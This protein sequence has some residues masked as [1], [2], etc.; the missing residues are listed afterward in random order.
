MG[1]ALTHLAN[2]TWQEGDLDGAIK[3][4]AAALA[5]FQEVG[6]KLNV[7]A[8]KD[9][10]GSVHYLEG[11]LKISRDLLQEALA[12]FRDVGSKSSVA[13]ALENLAATTFSQGD[14]EA[15]REM[16]EE[17]IAIDR[18]QGVKSEVAWGLAG[19]GD[20]DLAEAKLDDAS[21]N[22]QEALSLRIEIGEKGTIAESQLSIATLALEQGQPV[23]AE[24]RVRDAREEFRKEKQIDDE[25]LADTCLARALLAQHNY[26]EARKEI[27]AGKALVSRSQ[28]RANQLQL[29]MAA[30]EL[31]SDQNQLEEAGRHLIAIL[32]AAK[33]I[34]LLEYQF[35]ARLELGKIEM[36]SGKSSVGASHLH[37]LQEVAT[38]KGFLLIASKAAK[39]RAE[40]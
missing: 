32:S 2:V 23:A 1:T 18:K 30:G 11:H 28:N 5:N 38:T 29:E 3:G 34:G 17:A 22:Y 19:L 26:R 13:N 20:I 31:Y 35:K 39:E 16:L 12:G 10:L 37:A 14:L 6:D 15:A 21:R 24:T 33:Q 27:E 25:I 7:A 8:A 4:Y 9:N 40:H 36:K